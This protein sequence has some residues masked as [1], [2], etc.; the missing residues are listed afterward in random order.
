MKTRD[1]ILSVLK[2]CKPE[3]EKQ[4]KVQSIAM[5][6]SWARGDQ[7]PESDVDILVEVDPSIG[8]NFVSLAERLQ[9][10]LGVPVDLVSRRAVK[11]RNWKFIESDLIYV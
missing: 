2:V 8:L 7:Q 9:E 3:L 4:F 5:F 1:D 10:V 6:G 11:P